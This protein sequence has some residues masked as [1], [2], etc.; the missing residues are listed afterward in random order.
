MDE[1][2]TQEDCIY[3]FEYVVFDTCSQQ[4]EIPFC[5][6]YEDVDCEDLTYSV[7][8]QCPECDP[9]THD[10]CFLIVASV[11]KTCLSPG[12]NYIICEGSA[13][14]YAPCEELK[15]PGFVEV[16]VTWNY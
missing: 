3:R 9:L 6:G 7:D 8:I 5:S 1:C 14:K 10:P 2:T 12:G 13:Y 4:P 15:I 16:P 11:K